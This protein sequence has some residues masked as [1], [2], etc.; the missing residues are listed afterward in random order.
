M[1]TYL[2]VES[3]GMPTDS[4]HLLNVTPAIEFTE[5]EHG[6]TTDLL[7]TSPQ[8]SLG[9]TAGRYGEAGRVNIKY[10]L[11]LRCLVM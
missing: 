10:V 2:L 4:Y 3:R 11:N 5:P 1:G 7:G 8:A 6:P 9:M